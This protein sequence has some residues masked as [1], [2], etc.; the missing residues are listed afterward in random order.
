MAFPFR[1]AEIAR[2]QQLAEPAI[3][4]AVCR[5]ADGLDAGLQNETRARDKTDAVG[6]GHLVRADHPGERIAVG[7]RQARKAERLCGLD[8]LLGMRRPAQEAEIASRGQLGIGAHLVPT[9]QGYEV[10]T[11]MGS[12]GRSAD[13]I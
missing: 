7:Q 5:Q 8:Q 10:L 4:G 1:G 9:V 13:Y 3:G 6:L 12:F 11:K 2:G